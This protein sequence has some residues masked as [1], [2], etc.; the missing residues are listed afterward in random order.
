VKKDT[1]CASQNG[2]MSNTE[3]I[4][5]IV[6][7]FGGVLLDIDYNLTYE[8]MKKILHADFNPEFLSEDVKKIF[9]E[10][11]TGKSSVETFLWNIQRMAK[12]EVPHGK[13][14]I[15]AWNAMLIGWDGSKFDLLLALRKKY[16][17]FLLSNTNELHLDWVYADLVKNHKITDFDDQ[18]FD[19]TFYSHIMGY[20]KP[21]A[22][23]YYY[24][25]KLTNVVP[26]ETL[27]IDDLP[28]N[29]EAAKQVGWHGYLHNPA[30]NLSMVLKD[31]LHLNY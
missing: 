5:N 6:F 26:G 25:T 30:D 13:E 9:Y 1:N 10:F 24:V 27:F 21:D 29:I 19:K 16:N 4:K 23:I 7:D 17:V 22:E 28:Q 18:F 8:A 15:D 31:K 3:N 14:I 20:R 2:I 12:K 11:E